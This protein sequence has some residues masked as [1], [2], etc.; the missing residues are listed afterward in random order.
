MRKEDKKKK[1]FVSSNI[2]DDGSNNDDKKERSVYDSNLS[3][4][5]PRDPY[6]TPRF[7][8]FLR[9]W[10]KWIG[11]FLM[12][13]IV[14]LL[15]TTVINLASFAIFTVVIYDNF[16][17]IGFYL[18]LFAIPSLFI[19]LLSIVD[20]TLLC[21]YYGKDEDDRLDLTMYL[22]VPFAFTVSLTS[23]C[24]GTRYA[25]EIGWKGFSTSLETDSL[26]VVWLEILFLLS[27]LVLTSNCAS[28]WSLMLT[29]F[30][31]YVITLVVI[32]VVISGC[33]T[34]VL[35]HK[36]TRMLTFAF[37]NKKDRNERTV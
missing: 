36:S 19:S 28:V 15:T 2:G 23:V 31:L 5:P 14:I 16:V 30:Y 37:K 27:T 34:I 25:S 18:A 3:S 20:L 26:L 35:E 7:S 33:V 6:I 12:K 11:N 24:V 21:F 8:F 32:P 4:V 1:I 17:A 9:T 10:E 29:S 13:P 22:I